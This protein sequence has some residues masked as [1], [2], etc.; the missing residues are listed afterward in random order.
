[1]GGAIIASGRTTNDGAN[2]QKNSCVAS[3][4]SQGGSLGFEGHSSR[5]SVSC[6]AHSPNPFSVL[7][8]IR[9]QTYIILGKMC[10]VATV[11]DNKARDTTD[12]HSTSNNT[13]IKL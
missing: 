13:G 10:P 11:G 4:G 3:S 5:G 12:C 7:M 8:I 2:G 9:E 1:M 6:A